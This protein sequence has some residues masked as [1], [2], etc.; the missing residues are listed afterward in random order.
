MS[1]LADLKKIGWKTWTLKAEKAAPAP[2]PPTPTLPTPPTPPPKNQKT[3]PK[4]CR[5]AKD[6]QVNLWLLQ[7][8]RQDNKSN[9]FSAYLWLPRHLVQAS[10]YPFIIA[11]GAKMNSTL[12][13]PILLPI[14]NNRASSRCLPL[15]L[16]Q[17][18]SRMPLTSQRTFRRR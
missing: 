4:T 15:L 5:K 18:Q 3:K 14:Q 9:W 1:L 2:P 10:L 7:L 6:F 13:F 12:A 16:L 11:G 17:V 8:S